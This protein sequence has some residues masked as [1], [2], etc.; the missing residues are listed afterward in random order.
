MSFDLWLL[1]TPR[2]DDGVLPDDLRGDEKPSPTLDLSAHLA[3]LGGALSGSD[4]FIDSQKALERV[5]GEIWA[6]V[7][8][9]A[10]GEINRESKKFG[11]IKQIHSH[12]IGRSK[13]ESQQY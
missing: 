1:Y 12:R 4:L 7:L 11:R 6:S 5:R 8:T 3:L 13:I 10:A 2:S 9:K